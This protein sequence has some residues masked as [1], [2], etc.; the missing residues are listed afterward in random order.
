VVLSDLM[1]PQ[2]QNNNPEVVPSAI[3]QPVTPLR[4][5]NKLVRLVNIFYIISVC[6]LFG[7]FL[8]GL[9]QAKNGG[10]NVGTGLMMIWAIW[11][12]VILTV[13]FILARAIFWYVGRERRE[14]L[15][16]TEQHKDKRKAFI[17]L[18]IPGV[19]VAVFAVVAW[20]IFIAPSSNAR[21]TTTSALLQFSFA[22]SYLSI[23]AVIYAW[24]LRKT[25][26]RRVSTLVLSIYG[27]ACVIGGI[28]GVINWLIH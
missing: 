24:E 13:A 10:G 3:S 22:L 16:Y 7:L 14:G 27:A 23:L 1:E 11:T 26:Y 2:I 15:D 18:A 20:N 4:R 21:H 12:F 25:P 8:L 19:Q 9:L 6:F 5:T 28:I 17:A